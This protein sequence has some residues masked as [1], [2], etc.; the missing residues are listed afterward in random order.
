MAGEE[1]L[2][3]A[4]A[5]YNCAACRTGTQKMLFKTE[6]LAKVYSAMQQFLKILF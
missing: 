4:P 6:C 5:P 1:E 3:R 2:A